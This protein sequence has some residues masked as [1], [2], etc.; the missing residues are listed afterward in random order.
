M[1]GDIKLDI[2]CGANPY[3]NYVGIDKSKDVNPDI[4]LDVTKKK[5]PYD[6]LTVTTIRSSHFLEH[7][8]KEELISFMNECWRVL[9]WG[10]KMWHEVPHADCDLSRQDPTHKNQFVESSFK[11][12]CG[13]YLIKHKLDYGIKCIFEQ[14]YCQLFYPS[15]LSKDEKKYCTMI[16]FGLLK[17]I[18]H[19][20]KLKSLFPFNKKENKEKKFEPDWFKDTEWKTKHNSEFSRHLKQVAKRIVNEHMSEIMLIKVDAT[21][22]YGTDVAP[23]GMRGLFAD[24]NRKFTR[25]HRFIWDGEE[26]T[27]ENIKDTLYDLA[28]YSILSAMALD[29]DDT[30]PK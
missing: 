26:S 1:I 7:L 15:G 5:L 16:K 3:K 11:F 23:L 29:E 20:E 14:V 13:D 12:F 25:I 18:K 10:G 21:K 6:D 19:Y 27:S 28:V 24:L 2:G 9:K 30:I 17:N 4:V 22:R 8:S